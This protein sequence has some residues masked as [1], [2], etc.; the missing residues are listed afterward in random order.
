MS[1]VWKRNG[2]EKEG[3]TAPHPTAVQPPKSSL[4][5]RALVPHLPAT[6]PSSAAPRPT[7]LP[8]S[9]AVSS[10]RPTRSY[11]PPTPTVAHSFRPVASDA[12]TPL[13]PSPPLPWSSR[14]SPRSPPVW[15]RRRFLA[16]VGSGLRS[17]DGI[18]CSRE[19]WLVWIG[20]GCRELL[21]RA[22]ARGAFGYRS[23]LWG[24]WLRDIERRA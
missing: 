7:A 10:P 13:V 6:A 14:A 16:G 12:G 4:E 15:L 23:G 11:C 5:P 17:I 22:G 20:F 8:P 1:W 2:R 24:C 3:R 21:E 9:S 19:A 18:R